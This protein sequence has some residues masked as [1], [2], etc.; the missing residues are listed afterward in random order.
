[1]LHPLRSRIETVNSQLE[2]MGL[3]RMHA[4]TCP[5]VEIKLAASVLALAWIN[6]IVN[7]IPLAQ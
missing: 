7:A 6:I 3:E 1:M 4:R 2:T 5:G